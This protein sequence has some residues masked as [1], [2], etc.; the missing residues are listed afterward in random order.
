MHVPCYGSALSV[1]LGLVDRVQTQDLCSG[2]TWCG[3][4][5]T[6]NQHESRLT[7]AKIRGWY[8][9]N[10]S[11]YQPIVIHTKILNCKENQ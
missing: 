4:T 2:F 9:F 1:T 7:L 8:T 5:T 11:Y 10:R 3:R 6:S